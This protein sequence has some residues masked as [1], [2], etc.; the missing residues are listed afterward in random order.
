MT[1]RVLI[2]G[3]V[4]ENRIQIGIWRIFYEVM[5]R[6][7]QDVDYTLLLSSPPQQPIPPGV[8]VAHRRYPRVAWRGDVPG[9]IL[10]RLNELRIQRS[11]R[12]AIW[13]STYYT[14]DPGRDRASVVT[15]Y[16][17]IAERYF[18]IGGDSARAERNR[19]RAAIER[20]TS[21]LAI[22]HATA[23]DVQRF[24]RCGDQR[25]AVMPLGAEHLAAEP[26]ATTDTDTADVLYVGQRGSYKN[27]AAVIHALACE[28]WPS[29]VRLRVVG[30][31]FCPLEQDLHH[32]LGVADKIEH[33]GRLSEAQLGQA[34]RQS[35]CL[36]FPSLSEG[37]GIPVLE[38]QANA[39]VPVISDLPVFHEVAGE[40]ALFFNPND[41]RSL[42][43]AV[44]QAGDRCHRQR[45]LAAAKA[46]LERFSWDDAAQAVLE[47]YRQL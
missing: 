32:Y 3:V 6:T 34:Y 8:R 26:T 45:V 5:R 41:P 22:S 12:S 44:R 11:D 47:A 31:P 10:K 39:C 25:I 24:H 15:V 19:K 21:L 38:A 14:L 13:H 23:A 4:F 35:R 7:A 17:M 30:P 28:Q 18:A 36:V 2:D 9:R 37:F 16:D 33:L 43:E 20:A 29:G 1:I 46:N 42:C 40:G 27:Y